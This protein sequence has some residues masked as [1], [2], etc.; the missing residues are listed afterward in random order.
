MTPSSEHRKRVKLYDEPG[1]CHELT[2][3][4]FHRLPLLTNNVWREMLSRSI[5]RAIQRHTYHL[6]ALVYMPEHIH[7]LV[8]PEAN[9][10]RIEQLLKAIKRP[11]S[12]RIKKLLEQSGSPL[13]KK[14][15]IQQRPGVKT[16]RFWQEG[17]GYDRNLTEASTIESA[18]D[19]IHRNPVRRGLCQSAV[20]WR[21]SSARFYYEHKQDPALPKFQRVTTELLDSTG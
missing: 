14:L 13:L 9:S 6:F 19:Y 17:P 2:F 10:G 15:T 18:I 11:F 16:F 3:S 8:F 1:H 4:C 20:D 7:L 5:D 21:W 12:F